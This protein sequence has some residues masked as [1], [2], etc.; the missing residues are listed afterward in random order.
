MRFIHRSFD[1]RMVYIIVFVVAVLMLI[2][3]FS[4][5]G[6]EYQ[7]VPNQ[8]QTDHASSSVSE[9]ESKEYKP[10]DKKD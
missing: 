6:D 3:T 2:Q 9:A 8:V 10:G 7:S 1:I 4:K 5:G